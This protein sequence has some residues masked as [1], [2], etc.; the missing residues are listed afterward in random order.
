MLRRYWF[1]FE[2]K[3]PRGPR[4]LVCTMPWACGVTGHDEADALRHIEALWPGGLDSY[5]IRRRIEDLD[6]SDLATEVA[7]KMAPVDFGVPVVRGIWYPH[8]TNP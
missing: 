1:E 2:S 6:V 3:Q 7:A 4:D 5:A 8:L